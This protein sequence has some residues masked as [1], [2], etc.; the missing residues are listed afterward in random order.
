[1]ERE[2]E[3]ERARESETESER[4]LR[5]NQRKREIESE[6]A[7]ERHNRGER[8]SAIKAEIDWDELKEDPAAEACRELLARLDEEE[9]EEEEAKEPKEDHRLSHLFGVCEPLHF[10]ND[11]TQRAQKQSSSGSR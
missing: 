4:D 10:V 7:E 5:N 1:M 11:R 9:K 6:S 8:A 2:R 3:R